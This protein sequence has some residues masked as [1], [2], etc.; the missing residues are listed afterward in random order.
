MSVAPEPVDLDLCHRAS[1]LRAGRRFGTTKRRPQIALARGDPQAALADLPR[2]S[3][4]I[5]AASLK[6][7]AY[8]A[9]G[10]RADADAALAELE[11]IA[12]SD[13][14]DEIARI[15]ALR[16]DRD[17]AFTWLNRAYE[18]HD[19]GLSQ[20]KLNPDFNSLKTDPRYAA[21]LRKMKLPQ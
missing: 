20:I 17:A 4:P 15:Y 6:E 8:R 5:A 13:A 19:Y 18:L 3:S 7:R 2:V 14:P 12:A 16:D 1:R 9:L 21:F 11:N 10:R